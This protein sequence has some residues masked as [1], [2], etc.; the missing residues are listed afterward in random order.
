[1]SRTTLSDAK[2]SRIPE[3]L[4]LAPDDSRLLKYLNEAT[5]R[6]LT[7]GKWWGTYVKARMCATDGCITFPRQVAAIEAASICGQPI[8]IHDL[9]FEF[10]ENGFGIRG[11]SQTS[12]DSG[13][14][15]NACGM[16]EANY[17]GNFPAF[18]DIRGSDKQLRFVVDRASDACK[19]IL[20]LGYDDSTPPNWIRTNQGGVIK[21]GEVVCP[22]QSPGTNTVNSFSVLTDLQFSN[23]MDGQ[24]WLYE[25]DV[26]EQTQRLIGHYEYDETRPS[27]QRWYFPSIRSSTDCATQ[28]LVEVIAK[29]DFIPVK[30]DTD[31]LLIGNL[32]ALKMMCMAVK[33]YEEASNANDLGQAAG[34]EAMA[35]KLLD[36]ELDHHLGS[37]R[38]IGINLVGSSVYA[39]DPVENFI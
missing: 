35:V 6:L 31:Y 33:K 25:Y 24:T 30:N 1:M 37:G 29:L 10:L 4:N 36:D 26:A 9:F 15:G 12:E 8:P 28:S 32:P 16:M 5:E 7:K 17:R 23:N 34:F 38:R 2:A 20:V 18:D 11:N 27:Y 39:N 14:C 19:P 13:G 3:V 22:T 21:D